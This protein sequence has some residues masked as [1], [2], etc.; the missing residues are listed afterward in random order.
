MVDVSK[1]SDKN[2]E[3]ADT[4]LIR[5]P[6]SEFAQ[7]VP[8][9]GSIDMGG[10]QGAAA[11]GIDLHSRVQNRRSQQIPGYRRELYVSTDFNKLEGKFN[12]FAT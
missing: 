3:Y 11:S 4:C 9:Q 10:G 7:P 12:L 5:I 1:R 8:R 2:N 6:V